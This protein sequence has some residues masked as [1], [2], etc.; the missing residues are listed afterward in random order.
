[1][2]ARRQCAK[3]GNAGSATPATT[4]AKRDLKSASHEIA[5]ES[6]R[7]LENRGQCGQ[8][9]TGKRATGEYTSYLYGALLEGMDA[10]ECA[11]GRENSEEDS[12]S[13]GMGKSHLG[14]GLECREA[15]ALRVFPGGGLCRGHFQDKPDAG[16]SYLELLGY[17]STYTVSLDHASHRRGIY[18]HTEAH[19]DP[20]ARKKRGDSRTANAS[21]RGNAFQGSRGSVVLKKSAVSIASLSNEIVM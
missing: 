9:F 1:M 11:R 18:E 4:T 17:V 21:S 7:R 19:G 14:V 10:V 5:L 2:G 8:T 15:K 13:R 6:G 12:E 20:G 3:R 16:E